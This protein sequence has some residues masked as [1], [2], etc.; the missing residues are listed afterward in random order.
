ML[1]RKFPYQIDLPTGRLPSPMPYAPVT[2]ELGGNKHDGFGLIDS[3]STV[4]VLPYRA[5]L[6]L[7]AI[8]EK[9][10]IPLQLVGNLANYEARALF[11][12]AQIQGFPLTQFAFAWTKA[13]FARLI[14]GQTN[15]FTRFDVCFRHHDAEFELT[16]R[17]LDEPFS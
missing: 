8:W 1:S 15:F 4:N 12:N 10:T 7:G 16:M 14:L 5:G 17:E 13:E 3:G 2:L 9:Q 11:L 6:E